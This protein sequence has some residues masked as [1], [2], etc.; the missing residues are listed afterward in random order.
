MNNNEFVANILGMTLE[1]GAVE[2]IFFSN[3]PYNLVKA[4]ETKGIDP[5]SLINILEDFA[6][7][8]KISLSTRKS[9]FPENQLKL[10]QTVSPAV[11]TEEQKNQILLN[12]G[13]NSA[14]LQLGLQYKNPN[15]CDFQVLS[16]AINVQKQAGKTL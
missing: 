12:A 5:Q 16:S 10:L 14:Y 7:D 8:D 1:N 15:L 11:H 3:D 9:N 6:Y 13:T 4:C 2:E